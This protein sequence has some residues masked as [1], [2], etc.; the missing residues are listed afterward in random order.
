M[1]N[2]TFRRFLKYLKRAL[3]TF[4]D[5]VEVYSQIKEVY[6]C[7]LESKFSNTVLSIARQFE[8]VCGI[9]KMI[10]NIDALLVVSCTYCM[11]SENIGSRF[12]R[13]I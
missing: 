6:R 2:F 4:D 13:I 5:F 3:L 11:F 7:K 9:L 1:L 12:M 10:Q 8:F